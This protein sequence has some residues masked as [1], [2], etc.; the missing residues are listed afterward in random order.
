M[1]RQVIIA[2][3][4]WLA[5]GLITFAIGAYIGANTICSCPMIPV[6][7]TPAQIAQICHCGGYTSYLYAYVG[8]AAAVIGAIV[9]LLHRSIS[10]YA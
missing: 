3:V 8:T 7:A 1:D 5:V 10:A 2:G 9:L 6:N 4:G